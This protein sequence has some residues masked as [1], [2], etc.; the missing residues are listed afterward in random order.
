MR[1][2]LNAQNREPAPIF[3]NP[4]V[5]EENRLPM[6]SAYFPYENAELANKNVKSESDRFFDLNGTWKFF[7]TEHYKNLPDNFEATS[8]DDSNWDNFQVPAN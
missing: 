2:L 5:Q 8:F 6:R 1:K 3:E 7:W 4:K